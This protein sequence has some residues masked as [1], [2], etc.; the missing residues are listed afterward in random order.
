MLFDV[1]CM[2]LIV[3]NSR[4][5]VWRAG[6][7]T[8]SAQVADVIPKRIRSIRGLS[9]VSHN[10]A[11]SA[12]HNQVVACLRLR[13]VACSEGAV[14][15]IDRKGGEASTMANFDVLN[16]STSNFLLSAK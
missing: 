10:D 2:N 8:A 13:L 3:V 11:S 5:V 16:K 12:V 15:G 6:R 9:N 7:A 4:F 14:G 1:L